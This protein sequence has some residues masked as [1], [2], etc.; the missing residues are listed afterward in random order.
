MTHTHCIKKLLG[1]KDKNI[2][3]AEE[4]VTMEKI[5]GV[6]HFVVD[7]TLTYTPS[8]C[9]KCG[10]V[11]ESHGDIIKHGRKTSTIKLTHVNFQPVLLKLKKQRFLCKHCG[12][13]F[14]AETKLVD[15]HCYIANS[16]KSTIAMELREIQSMALIAKHMNVSSHT[17]LRVLE[18]VG[19]TLR[20]KYLYLP[21]HLS[22]DE[23]KSV[24]N[25]S[26]A[27]SFLFMDATNHRLIDIVE[28]R[29]LSY[30]VDYFLRYPLEA[31]LSVKTVTMDMY[32]PYFQL[33]AE[34]FPNAQVVIDRF[35]IVQ[36]LNRGLN[37]VRIQ[38][39]NKIRY[40]RP[41]DY[42]K[43]KQQWKLVLKNQGSLDYEKLRTHRLYDGLVT[44]TMM[45]AYLTSLSPELERVYTL[46]NRLKEALQDHDFQRFQLEL[47]ESRKYRLPK[48]MRTIIQT[49][50][51]YREEI[52]N[53][54]RFTLSNGGLEGL[55]NKVK[56]IKRSGFGYRNFY[57][58]R[59]RILISSRLVVNTFKPRP[60]L[61]ADEE[62]NKTA[63]NQKNKVA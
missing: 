60:V 18:K 52:Q 30:L 51:R 57:N 35:H 49:L 5:E 22:I 42:R 32:S 17:V 9:A 41:R 1:L 55:N 48:K 61:F 37:S 63:D 14:T 27:M 54:C 11:N 6:N 26:G 36:H 19:A 62:K 47:E 46:V 21:R 12:A 45:V 50:Q 15:R 29:Q 53:A 58:L 3:L 13:T 40:E 24:K 34:V 56:N 4:P 43:L 39:M 31:R 23:F 20:P 16:I 28:N 10:V 38:T 25:V 44:Q 33:V 8:C 2:H 59:A 7:G